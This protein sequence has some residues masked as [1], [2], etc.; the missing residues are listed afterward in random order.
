MEIYSCFHAQSKIIQVEHHQSFQNNT[1]TNI[2]PIMYANPNIIQNFPNHTNRGAYRPCVLAIMTE[3]A[4]NA[5]GITIT[6]VRPIF[7][8]GSIFLKSRIISAF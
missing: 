8:K 6:V 5:N 2:P 7:I 3:I 1:S 4:D